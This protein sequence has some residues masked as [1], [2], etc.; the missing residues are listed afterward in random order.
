MGSDPQSYLEDQNFMTVDGI[1]VTPQMWRDSKDAQRLARALKE[2]ASLKLQADRL[3][4]ELKPRTD[5]SILVN[6]LVAER[7]GLPY[8]HLDVNGRLV[9]LSMAEARQVAFDLLTMCGRTEADAMIVRF[10]KDQDLP[11]G[12]AVEM[13]VRFRDFRHDLDLSDKE[14]V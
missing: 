10:F 6:G 13:L 3:V 2:V 1:K 8:I 7:D 14:R 11:Q 9:Q 5:T 12:A 4:E